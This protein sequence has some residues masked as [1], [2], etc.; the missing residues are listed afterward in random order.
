MSQRV[1]DEYF[2]L[3]P[4]CEFMSAWNTPGLGLF[5]SLMFVKVSIVYV[6]LRF[7]ILLVFRAFFEKDFEWAGI[8]NLFAVI[9][10]VYYLG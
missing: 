5:K 10:F 1:K 3:T 9:Y 7:L 4:G 8:M 6:M 2:V